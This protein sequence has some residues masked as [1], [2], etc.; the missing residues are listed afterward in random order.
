[1]R[2]TEIYCP[3]FPVI[4]VE[5]DPGSTTVSS[6]LTAAAPEPPEPEPAEPAEP[7]TRSEFCVWQCDF[8]RSSDQSRASIAPAEEIFGAALALARQVL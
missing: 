8:A 4:T 5:D 6:G 1:M 3:G 2:R 7:E